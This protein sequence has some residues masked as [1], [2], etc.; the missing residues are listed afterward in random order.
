MWRCH[1]KA[2]R[3]TTG[4]APGIDGTVS[5]KWLRLRF[6]CQ[7]SSA[8]KYFLMHHWARVFERSTRLKHDINKPSSEK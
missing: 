4:K 1:G 3:R 7:T 6:A 8:R 5:L 2:Q